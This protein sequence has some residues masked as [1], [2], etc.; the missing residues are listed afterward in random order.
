MDKALR[1]LARVMV[2]KSRAGEGDGNN[3]VFLVFW[4]F[5]FHLDSQ[6]SLEISDKHFSPQKA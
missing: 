1:T 3:G 4:F 6:S 2:Q 5:S